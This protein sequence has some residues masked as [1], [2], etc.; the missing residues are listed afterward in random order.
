MTV[1][2]GTDAE[3]VAKA[4]EGTVLPGESNVVYSDGVEEILGLPEHMREIA[5]QVQSWAQQAGRGVGSM[6]DRK[7]WA[8]SENPFKH[9]EQS[10]H[11]LGSND[12]VSGFYELIEG[13]AFQGVKWEGDE[14]DKTDLFN[15]MAAEQN[16]DALVRKHYREI[17]STSQVVTAAWWDQGEFTV[18]GKTEKGNARKKRYSVY[19]PRFITILDNRRV[20]PVGMLAFGQERLAWVATSREMAAFKALQAG[21][22]VADDVVARFFIAKYDPTHEERQELAAFGLEPD[23]LILLNP[24]LVRR[25]TLTRSDYERFAP[26]RLRSIFQLMDLRQQLMEADRVTLVGAANYILLVKKGDKDHPA[27]QAEVNNVRAGFRTL[28]KVPVIFSDHR[29]SI[30]MITPKQDQTLQQEKYDLIDDRIIQ[31]LITTLMRSGSAS[32]RGGQQGS[33]G[34]TVVRTLENQRHM[35]RRHLEQT[36]AR[37]VMTHPRNAAAFRDDQHAPS[38]IYVPGSIAIDDA[39][40][41]AQQVIALRTMRELSRESTLEFF[42]FDQ[43]AEAL[44]MAVEKTEY[45]D[46]F[47]SMVP[48]SG[49]NQGAQDGAGD[50][51]QGTEEPPVTQAPNGAKGGRPTGGGQPSQNPQKTARTSRGTTKT[52]GGN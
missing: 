1:T 20:V 35:L 45:D 23:S 32:T 18:R 40:S 13:L 29:L 27:Q 38:L 48:F 15:Q 47:K 24:D 51:D 26:V 44:R 16:L 6:L 21:E 41:L 5:S 31:R 46:T 17:W 8:P 2:H 37:E 3:A 9:F 39:N 25:H 42:G 12:L 52:K 28:A 14:A 7:Q 49:G 33:I 22:A 43:E 36:L 11:L 4:Y 19:Y 10:H 30:E 50:D 34:T